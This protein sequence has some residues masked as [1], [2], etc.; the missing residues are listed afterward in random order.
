MTE[1][2]RPAAAATSAAGYKLSSGRCVASVAVY[3]DDGESGVVVTFE[4]AAGHLP[5][6][7]RRELVD[8]VFELPELRDSHHLRVSIPLGDAELLNSLHEHCHHLNAR[9]AGSTCLLE[10]DLD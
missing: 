5:T 9:A 10:G 4:I 7:V 8:A 1:P 3:E 2:S 6:H